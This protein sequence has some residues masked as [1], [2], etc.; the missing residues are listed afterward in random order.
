[1]GGVVEKFKELRKKNKKGLIIFLTAGDPDLKTTFEL[2]KEIEKNG[3]DIVELGIPF[4]DPIADG[5]IIQASS[6]RALK[7]NVNIK[8]ILEMTKELTREINIPVILMSYYNPVFKYGIEKFL[9]DCRISKVAGL[10]I[11]DLLPEESQEIRELSKKNDIDLIFL[12]SPTTSERRI[13]T[14]SRFSKG[15]IYCVSRTGTTGIQKKLSEDLE[16]FI[17]KVRKITKKPLAVGF[18]ISESSHVKEVAK[19]SDAVIVGSAVV[20]LIEENLKSP[21][22]IKKVGEFVKR[23]KPDF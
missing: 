2:V 19:I 17:K 9:K 12:I 13:K 14:I 4:S 3:A 8:K 1:M 7:N 22:L 20:K 23:L 21:Y 16:E 6:Q 15:F 5:P 18:G 10:I 11:S